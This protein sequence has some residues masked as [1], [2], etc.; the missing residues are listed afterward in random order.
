MIRNS[1]EEKILEKGKRKMVLDQLIVSVAPL[2]LE[3]AD[4]DPGRRCARCR[5]K[6]WPR[7]RTPT[8]AA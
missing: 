3:R 5:S 6:T 2:M 1:V 8:S 7:R 4:A